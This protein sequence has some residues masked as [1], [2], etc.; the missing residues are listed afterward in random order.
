MLGKMNSLVVLR[1]A[2]QGLYLD[3]ENLGDVLIPNNVVPPGTLVGSRLDVFLYCDSDDRLIATT[4]VP[5]AQVGEFAS[6]Q[7]VGLDSRIGAFLDWGLNKD[8]LLPI[9]E[10]TAP[11]QEGDWR[12]VYLMVDERSNRI[13]ATQRLDRHLNKTAP[14]YREGEK[15]TLLIAGET[16]L[17]YK[18][19]VEGAHRGLIY[20]TDVRVRLYMGQKVPGYVKCVREDGKIDLTL[21]PAGWSRVAP[22]ADGIIEE[23]KANGGKLALNDDSSPEEI[24][25]LLG[26]SKKSFKQ[27][28]GV[29]Y[30]ERRIVM[31]EHGISLPIDPPDR[32]EHAPVSKS[33]VWMP[34]PVAPRTPPIFK[35]KKPN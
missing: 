13:V 28:I 23:L 31:L 35:P 26:V 32:P 20:H 33:G 24:R 12:L 22:L 29:L 6:L 1:V 9:R 19:I 18:A 8:V 16:D 3:G 27:A 34:R 10:Q 4:K 7:V 25:A 15:V 21:D 30:K 5:F 11:L 2:T 14:S 17:G